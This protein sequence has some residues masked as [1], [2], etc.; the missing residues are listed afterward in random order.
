MDA[1]ISRG[2]NSDQVSL[3]G[4]KSYSGDARTS[5]KVS[6]EAGAVNVEHILPIDIS[7]IAA[8]FIHAAGDLTIKTNSSST[9]DDTLAL[10]ADE[11]YVWATG[12]YSP[13]LLDADVTKVFV[14]NAGAAAVTLYVECLYDPT[15]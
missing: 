10:K 4:R 2:I 11:P 5:L 1:T 12:D 6:I 14:S 9:P 3:E 15:P 7:Q 8:L 13:L